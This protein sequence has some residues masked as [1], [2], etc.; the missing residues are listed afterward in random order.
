MQHIEGSCLCSG[1]CKV[2][3]KGRTAPLCILL[4][5]TIGPATGMFQEEGTGYEVPRKSSKLEAQSQ[6]WDFA[7]DC[8][9]QMSLQ[10]KARHVCFGD[11]TVM[12]AV[13]HI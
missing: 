9:A 2:M 7:A 11:T 10:D 6:K 12:A 3:G 8:L 5:E 1:L 4:H 13:G